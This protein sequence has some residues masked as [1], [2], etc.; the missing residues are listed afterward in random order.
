MDEGVSERRIVH[1]QPSAHNMRVGLPLRKTRRLQWQ[2]CRGSVSNRTL[3][4]RLSLAAN[5]LIDWPTFEYISYC[6]I[7]ILYLY[8]YLIRYINL[9]EARVWPWTRL[10]RSSKNAQ[11]VSSRSRCDCANV[12]LCRR[13]LKPCFSIQAFAREWNRIP[14]LWNRGIMWHQNLRR[15]KAIV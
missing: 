8:I 11:G 15:P 12:T 2:R 10:S 3:D 7:L 6:H 9:T 4:F 5:L 13:L 14:I 1:L